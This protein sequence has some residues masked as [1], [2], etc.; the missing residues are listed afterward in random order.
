MDDILQDVWITAFKS[1]PSFRSNGPDAFDRWLSVIVNRRLADALRTAGAIKRGAAHHVLR[2][3]DRRQRSCADLFGRLAS[4]QRTPSREVS[5]REA[6]DAVLIALSSLADSR[7]RAVQMCYIEGCSRA[8]IAQAMRR[9]SAA[10]N[11]LIYH[12]L[13]E[14][15][16]RLGQADHFLSGDGTSAPHKYERV[17][18]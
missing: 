1:Y 7:R 6:A 11:S 5:A 8:E 18:H 16:A 14:L 10:V 12:G 3:S 15:R 9:S 2:D 17:Q 4:S 13:R